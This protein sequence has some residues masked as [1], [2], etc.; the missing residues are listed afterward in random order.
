MATAPRSDGAEGVGTPGEV[1]GVFNP[2]VSVYAGIRDTKG[3][4][5]PMRV[6]D[7]LDGIRTGRWAAQVLAVRKA[8]T[9]KARREAKAALPCPTWS[10]TFS[11][12]VD[13]ALL[14]HSGLVCLDFDLDNSADRL[15]I[16]AKLRSDGHIFAMFRSPGGHGVKAL[17]RIPAD[18]KRHRD[19]FIAYGEHIN[20]VGWDAKC[21]NESRVNYV[22]HDPDME[23]FPDAVEW[24]GLPRKKKRG[25]TVVSLPSSQTMPEDE[26][27]AA[28]IAQADRSLDFRDGSRNSSAFTLA[29]W[30]NRAGLPVHVAEGAISR[31]AQDGFGVDEIRHAVRSAYT[32]TAE[33]G[34]RPVTRGVVDGDF[35]TYFDAA[36]PLPDEATD[37]VVRPS[38]WTFGE[39]GPKVVHMQYRAWLMSEG[40]GLHAPPG[41][42]D[43]SIFIRVVDGVVQQITTADIK[44][45][46]LAYLMDC[47][48]LDVHEHMAGKP[49]YFTAE[50]LNMLGV[51]DLDIRRDG[52]QEA[53]LYYADTA[54]RVTPEGITPVPYGEIQGHVWREHILPRPWRGGHVEEADID[55][56]DWG[57][58]LGLIAGDADNAD[59]LL[60]AIGYMLHT[61]RIGAGAKMIVLM[62]QDQD[63][64]PQGGTG[65]GLLCRGI[66]MLR[67]RVVESGKTWKPDRQFAYQR[68][69]LDTQVFQIDDAGKRF[70]I[71]L[72]FPLITEGVPVERKGK[73]AFFI[74]VEDAP[75]LIMTTNY[76]PNGKGSSFERRIHTVALSGYFGGHRTPE[77]EFGHP[78]FDGWGDDQ[79]GAFDL[80]QAMALQLYLRRGLA[81][82]EQEA[83]TIRKFRHR[84]A[85]EFHEWAKDNLVPGVRYY[86][87]KVHRNFVEAYKDFDTGKTRLPERT[88]YSWCRDWG[89]FNGWEA[90]KGKDQS[91]R[92]LGYLDKDHRMCAV[93]D[94]GEQI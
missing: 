42:V 92:W 83:V 43:A 67:R 33:H 31:Y 90:D 28:L 89:D 60:R 85:P 34:T 81:G 68:I 46:T 76:A 37:V 88:F 58:F 51:V 71:E 86:Q 19:H 56:S 45:H 15:R 18:A 64:N 27:A 4:G 38:F 49:G 16:M 9:D 39:R 44:R 23:I 78:M 8:T 24:T 41:S 3:G 77:D 13:A 2:V 47:G 55:G 80:I 26:A 52:R 93:V 22:S 30:F 6:L 75:K 12:R 57:R 21:K 11:E 65:K 48:E 29:C 25:T 1:P 70:D 7:L 36:P 35:T 20:E 66:G 17:L 14:T 5:T 32:H 69:T 59:R 72:L 53:M 54:V 94:D 63:D 50:Y 40:F 61:H 79:W 74:P 10:G 84:T 91:G 82:G 87:P 62:D 73:D